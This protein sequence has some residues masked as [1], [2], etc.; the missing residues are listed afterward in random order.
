MYRAKN[1]FIIISIFICSTVFFVSCDDKSTSAYTGV[2]L[3]DNTFSPPV[4]RVH[5]GG[6]VRFYNAGN[7]PHN[8]LAVDESWGNYEDIP[9]NDYVDVSF[10]IEGLYKYI[11]SYHATPEGD[12]GMAGAVVVGDIDY[13]AAHEGYAGGNIGGFSIS[14]KTKELIEQEVKKLIDFDE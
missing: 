5:E 13:Q 8:V 7:N 11:C 1:I 14:T 6:F 2:R 4:V 3:I 10:P 9:K 12:W